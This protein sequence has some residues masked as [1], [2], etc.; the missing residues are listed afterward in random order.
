[1]F[2]SSLFQSLVLGALA[3]FGVGL[4]Y[5]LF[6]GARVTRFDRRPPRVA[7]NGPRAAA[8]RAVLRMTTWGLFF[9]AYY[10]FVYFLGR[11]LGWWALAPSMA[12]LAAMIW[13]LLQAD[14][15]LTVR[16]EDVRE[17]L[18]IGATLAALLAVFAAVIWFAAQDD[19]AR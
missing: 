18:G 2:D 3:L 9:G 6:L 1:M 17:Q 7:V 16:A 13:A 12:G 11:R 4:V 5:F 10:L 19:W 15:L 8:L 14:R